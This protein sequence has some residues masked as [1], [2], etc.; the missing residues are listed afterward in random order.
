MIYN[1][2]TISINGNT[3]TG[4]GT[5]WTAAAS[6]IRVSQTIIVLSNPVQMF[7]ITAI[8][9]GTSVTV[10]PAAS[11]ALSGQKYGILVTDSLSVDGLAQS[12]SQLINEYDENIGAWETFASTS[13]NQLVTVT[14]NGTSLS[15]PAIGGLARKGENSDITELKGLTTPLS[16]KQGG[17]GANNAADARTNLGL[18]SAALLDQIGT[19]TATQSFTYATFKSNAGNPL[20]ISSV[21]PTIQFDETDTGQQFILVADGSGIRLNKDSTGGQAIFNYAPNLLRFGQPI[22]VTGDVG[23]ISGV[24]NSYATSTSGNCHYWFRDVAGGSRGVMYA[25]NNGVINL[26][27][28]NGSTGVN[29]YA[30]GFTQAGQAT[31]VNWNSTSDD[32]V[33][34]KI[35][36]V[37]NALDII[38]K[39]NG[40]TYNVQSAEDFSVKS[41][42][43]L[44]SEIEAI[45]PD[46]VVTGGSGYD[47]EGNEI[48]NIKSVNY[49]ALSAYYIEAIKELNAEVKELKKILSNV[50]NAG[51]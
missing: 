19:W 47:T 23:C 33:K 36:K 29:G 34:S 38:D 2:G 12:M 44:A 18:G 30:F 4:T 50:A 20:K 43:V 8:N 48:D 31:A 27:P 5:N 13:A 21:N 3:A 32:R 10:T 49:T 6:Q 26:R 24:F 22:T 28:D 42:G 37:D 11:P 9:S 51:N 46:F 41:A 35:N 14:I 7:Q 40:Y 45:L 39:L 1:T 15:I 17:L 25:S 16:L